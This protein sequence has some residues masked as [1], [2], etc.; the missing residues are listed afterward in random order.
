M[1]TDETSVQPVEGVI[2]QSMVVGEGAEKR[3]NTGSQ[4]RK[5]RDCLLLIGQWWWM[6]KQTRAENRFE[7]SKFFSVVSCKS[8]IPG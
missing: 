1:K 4:Q 5:G 3:G 7:L 8:L 6:S 2:S